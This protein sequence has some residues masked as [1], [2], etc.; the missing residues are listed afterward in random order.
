VPQVP[1]HNVRSRHRPSF[2]VGAISEGSEDSL[3]LCRSFFTR[4]FLVSAIPFHALSAFVV[5]SPCHLPG[6]DDHFTIQPPQCRQPKHVSSGMDGVNDPFSFL[7][8]MTHFVQFFMQDQYSDGL[9]TI[10][11]VLDA[12]EYSVNAYYSL[13]NDTVTRF[14][15][16]HLEGGDEWPM[17]MELKEYK[18]L[19]G[20]YR[21]LWLSLAAHPVVLPF[22]LS[23][24]FC[25]SFLS[26]CPL[27]F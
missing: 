8:H 5:T 21:C 24:S 7:F 12:V 22:S 10:D 18:D 14:A 13:P 23:L 3:R 19:E 2:S 1:A 17:F 11:D 27:V 15:F 16:F 4:I 26:F 20:R 25:L 6:T 9:Y